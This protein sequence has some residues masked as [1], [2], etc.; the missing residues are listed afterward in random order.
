[1]SISRGQGQLMFQREGRDPDVVFRDRGAGFSQLRPDATV[2][3]RGRQAGRKQGDSGEEGLDFLDVPAGI[4]RQMRSAIEFAKDGLGK[5][6][7]RAGLDLRS[8]GGIAP[9]IGN[10]D[11]G[12]QK[13]LTTGWH[14]SFRS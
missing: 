13:N 9:E 4:L 8:D 11:R 5:E 3:F 12:V 14:Q 10:D 7:G 1:M 6:Q 2:V